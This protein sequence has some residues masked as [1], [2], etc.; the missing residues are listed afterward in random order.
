MNQAFSLKDIPSRADNPLSHTGQDF[1]PICFFEDQ[2]VLGEI[3]HGFL[4]S[5]L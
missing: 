4:V 1:N 5:P 3:F 2:D